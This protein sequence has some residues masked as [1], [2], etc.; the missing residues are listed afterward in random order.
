MGFIFVRKTWNLCGL[1]PTVQE[2]WYCQHF[3]HFQLVQHFQSC[4][5]WQLC[6][7]CYFLYWLKSD[8]SRHYITCCKDGPALSQL[9]PKHRLFTYMGQF[10]QD[11]GNGQNVAFFY[12]FGALA[13]GASEQLKKSNCLITVKLQKNRNATFWPFSPSWGS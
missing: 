9:P 13:F 12:F 7:L 1:S 3:Q 4:Q 2:R 11:G 10:P 8:P 5:Q 6:Q